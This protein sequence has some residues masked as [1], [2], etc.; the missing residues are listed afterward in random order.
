MGYP[1]EQIREYSMEQRVDTY[2]VGPDSK[3]RFSALCRY[4]QEVSERH[5]ESVDMGYTRMK[6]EG[7]VFLII[8]NRAEIRRLPD[9]GEELILRTH[10]RGTMG[11]SFYRDYELWAGEELLVRVMQ[12]SVSVDPETHKLLRPKVFF[13]YGVFEDTRTPREERNVRIAEHP[14]LPEIG[15][16]PIRYSDIDYNHHLN[17]AV[18]ADIAMDVVPDA[19]RERPYTGMQI[20]YV[21]EALLGEELTLRGG[22]TENGYLVQGYH[23]RGLSFSMLLR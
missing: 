20:D 11:A 22:E 4:C 9:L 2:D 8:S 3:L 23:A 5:L 12:D 6:R 14:E 19:W 15:R 21:S 13:S 17:N 16:R 1:I 7:L 10:P 18:Y